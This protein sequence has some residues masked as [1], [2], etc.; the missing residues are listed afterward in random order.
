[1]KRYL[2]PILALSV[3]LS[4]SV[5]AEDTVIKT[6][7]V[8]GQSNAE[9]Y[10]LGYGDLFSGALVPNQNLQIWVKAT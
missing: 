1:M 9:G 10:G 3:L 8:A 5:K 2:L 7:I 6:Y 4:A